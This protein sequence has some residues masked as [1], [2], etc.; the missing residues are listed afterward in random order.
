M[1]RCNAEVA[2]RAA[3]IVLSL[4]D[5]AV[6][7]TVARELASAPNRKVK[8][9]IDTSTI[10]IKAAEARASLLAASAIEYIDALG[11]WRHFRSRQGDAR[12]HAGLSAAEL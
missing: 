2:T 6:S 3:T 5:G 1:A 8:T 10:G 11:V 9:V 12:H 4:P 7:H